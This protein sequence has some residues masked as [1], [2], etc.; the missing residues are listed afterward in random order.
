MAFLILYTT[1]AIVRD[2]TQVGE[3]TVRIHHQ[4]EGCASDEETIWQILRRFQIQTF[5][6]DAPDH[7][8]LSWH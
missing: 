4:E 1:G 6:F 3:Q 5:D 2:I 8:P 7:N